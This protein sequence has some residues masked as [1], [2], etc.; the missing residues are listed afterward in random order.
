M[1]FF[2]RIRR[3]FW[4]CLCVWLF[5]YFLCF[6][7]ANLRSFV[8]FFLYLCVENGM[9]EVTDMFWCC[10]F[11]VV[12]LCKLCLVYISATL[13]IALYQIIKLFQFIN[14]ILNI[15]EFVYQ[16]G[17]SKKCFFFFFFM[18]ESNVKWKNKVR[19]TYRTVCL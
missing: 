16:F 7:F 18:M 15:C 3:F 6:S 4:M 1:I 2:S 19:P 14:S 9:K 17:M 11:N 5:L 8:I 12:V 10:C 13:R